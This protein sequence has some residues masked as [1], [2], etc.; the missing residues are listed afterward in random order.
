MLKLPKIHK[1]MISKTL[2]SKSVSQI[3]NQ[4]KWFVLRSHDFWGYFRW[5]LSHCETSFLF[6]KVLRQLSGCRGRHRGRRSTDTHQP[7]CRLVCMWLLNKEAPHT[8]VSWSLVSTSSKSA[9]WATQLF[10]S[11]RGCCRLI[12]SWHHDLH[13]STNVPSS[14]QEHQWR[15]HRFLLFNLLLLLLSL[16]VKIQLPNPSPVTSQLT[17]A[18]HRTGLEVLK[19]CLY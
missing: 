9:D 14:L 7:S 1:L 2:N 16:L 12:C 4:K 19:L 11:S 13:P 5:Q 18:G 10:C 8:A 6:L 3:Y 17:A 15:K